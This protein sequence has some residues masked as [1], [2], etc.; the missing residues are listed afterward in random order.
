MHEAVDLRRVA[1]WVAT[2]AS[3]PESHDRHETCSWDSGGGGEGTTIRHAATPCHWGPRGCQ[4]RGG[5]GWATTSALGG[6]PLVR[7]P[8]VGKSAVSRYSRSAFGPVP[9]SRSGAHGIGRGG[10]YQGRH[11]PFHQGPATHTPR[12]ERT[13]LVS[14]H[15]SAKAPHAHPY[16]ARCTVGLDRSL[17]INRGKTTD[18]QDKGSCGLGGVCLL[19]GPVGGLAATATRSDE[20]HSQAH[21]TPF[22]SYS[23]TT[24]PLS[25]A[26][27]RGH[28]RPDLHDSAPSDQ[29]R[30][31]CLAEG[32]RA[33]AGA[34]GRIAILA[35][36]SLGRNRQGQGCR[37]N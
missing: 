9:L 23:S 33:Q 27:K 24:R 13:E 1:T 31:E 3:V 15:R 11:L 10:H 22:Q 25:A 28:C 8:S 2:A 16:P 7:S 37:K 4:S 35:P 32:R 20:G 30:Q 18:V 14:F 12:D 5:M 34:C 26:L 17:A 36:A 29:R 21:F 19:T 6:W